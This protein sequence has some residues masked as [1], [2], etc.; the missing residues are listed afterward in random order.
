MYHTHIELRWLFISLVYTRSMYYHYSV[1]NQFGEL[2]DIQATIV[3]D[4][5]SISLMIFE[6]VREYLGYLVWKKKYIFMF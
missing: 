4:L 6:T 3:N 5:I 2:E 1:E